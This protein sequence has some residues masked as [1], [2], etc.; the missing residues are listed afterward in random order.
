MRPVDTQKSTVAGP[1][2]WRLGARSVPEASAPWQLEQFSS[3][4]VWPGAMYELGGRWYVIVLLAALVADFNATLAAGGLAIGAA[5]RV[6]VVAG[7]VVGGVAAWEAVR[8]R[9][10]QSH[11]RHPRHQQS[12]QQ[13]A[14]TELR[15][16]VLAVPGAQPVFSRNRQ[17]KMPI[18]MKSTKCQ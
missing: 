1:S 18:H 10:Q 12:R 9:R 4:R 8:A 6:A 3:N 14:H 16:H 2:P 5:A 17:L 7:A 13:I 15:L 11:D